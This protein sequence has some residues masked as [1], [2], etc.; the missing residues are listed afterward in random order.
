MAQQML[1]RINYQPE[2]DLWELVFGPMTSMV[3]TGDV[4]AALAE[5][6][7]FGPKFKD[8]THLSFTWRFGQDTVEMKDTPRSTYVRLVD[9][10][11]TVV[12]AFKQTDWGKPRDGQNRIGD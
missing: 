10:V 9:Y 12:E 1:F 11:E 8:Q 3:R 2:T 6:R 7:S 4:I 5:L